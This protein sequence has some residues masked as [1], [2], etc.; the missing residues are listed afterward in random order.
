MVSHRVKGLRSCACQYASGHPTL[1][2]D[3]SR[4]EARFQESANKGYR[5]VR[6]VVVAEASIPSYPVPF[7]CEE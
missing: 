5:P 6:T 3:R 4:A 7:Y 1:T 2:G